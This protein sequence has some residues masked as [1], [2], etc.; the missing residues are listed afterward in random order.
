MGRRSIQREIEVKVD[1]AS[2]T[3]G[4]QEAVDS[5]RPEGGIVRPKDG[6]YLLKTPV[7]MKNNTN[8][9]VESGL[10]SILRG[11]DVITKVA[12]RDIVKGTKELHVADTAGLEPGILF[13]V[14]SQRVTKRAVRNTIARIQ[15]NCLLLADTWTFSLPKD[16][17]TLWTIRPLIETHKVKNITI[18]DIYL[19]SNNRY[20]GG[21]FPNTGWDT[22]MTA[23]IP[24]INVRESENVEISG[25]SIHNAHIAGI[26]IA[27]ITVVGSTRHVAV[28]NCIFSHIAYDAIHLGGS[29]DVLVE[30]NIMYCCEYQ[31]GI[32]FC[33]HS[34]NVVVRGN[35][36]YNCDMGIPGIDWYDTGTKIY[37]NIIIGTRNS[38]KKEPSLPAID[39]THD[40][41]SPPEGGP[42][43][44]GPCLVRNN[45]LLNNCTAHPG[46]RSGI[47]MMAV[48]NSRIEDNYIISDQSTHRFGIET[49]DQCDNLTIEDNKSWGNAESIGYDLKGTNLTLHG[50][51]TKMLNYTYRF[52]GAISNGLTNVPFWVQIERIDR[53][54]GKRDTSFNGEVVLRVGR[55]QELYRIR[56]AEG[57]AK[58]EIAL[59]VRNDQVLVCTDGNATAVSNPFDIVAGD[60]Q[61]T[62]QPTIERIRSVHHFAFDSIFKQQAKKPFEITVRA[63]DES[64]QIATYYT[65]WIN[66]AKITD[67]G[68]LIHPIF[69][70]F[71]EG[72]A[73]AKVTVPEPIHQMTF[74]ARRVD[75]LMI[76]DNMDVPL[77]VITGESNSLEILPQ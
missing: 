33:W 59:P 48:H 36:I 51:E 43:N 41:Y 58:F 22:V 49:G 18:R 66:Y 4:I 52:V 56:F 6:V 44:P 17:S 11:D 14:P 40:G 28:R 55:T 24:S 32:Y 57:L 68:G 72:I 8:L 38:M 70:F 25:C 13:Y 26:I 10:K 75:E 37:D 20:Y 21:P 34:K 47:H 16:E 73:T 65:G 15:G 9:V 54:S 19:D 35:E 50:N 27:S 12:T 62:R 71:Q 45:L 29:E 67:S 30:N 39:F 42:I 1:P 77:L 3:S 5:L 76:E 53:R 69:V 46:T 23:G 31:A 7:F 63:M 2:L 60:N 61:P 74:R 64:G